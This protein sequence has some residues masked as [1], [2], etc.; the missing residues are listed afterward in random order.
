[1]KI[2]VT[3]GAGFIGSHIVDA[4]L[5][6]GHSVVIIDSLATGKK[7]NLN[8]DAV[9]YKGDI[10]DRAFV[11]HVFKEERV[12]VVNHH[13]AHASVSESMRNPQFDAEVNII[14]SINLVEVA[15]KNSVEKFI[16]ASTGGAIYGDTR[17]NPT[18][19]TEDPHPISPY[20]VS[21]LSFEHYLHYYH[22]VHGLRY[23]SL[24]YANVYGE[25][26][27]PFGEAGVVAIFCEKFAQNKKVEIFGDGEQTRDYVYVGDVVRA[28]ILALE[29][30]ALYR[31]VNIGTG[32]ETSVNEL[33]EILS[34]IAGNSLKPVY[35]EKRSGEQRRSVLDYSLAKHL[36][37]WEPKY[38]FTDESSRAVQKNTFNYFKK[39]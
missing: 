34:D 4:Y 35:A 10:T 11:E 29:K 32:K 23:T 15:C 27:D 6:K 21:K 8:P 17:V 39:N 37:L 1:M 19:E 3:G 14:G 36:L 31:P 13:A 16:F 26:Q 24:R 18:P 20:G 30:D 12:D 7:K 38:V 22:N 2:L 33:Y 5:D 25:R 9:F 28:N